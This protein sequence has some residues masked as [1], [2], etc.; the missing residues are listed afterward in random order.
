[1]TKAFD[2]ALRLLVRREHGAVELC[3][4]LKKKGFSQEE[5]KA[6]VEECQHLGYQ[7]DRR[8]VENYS[9]Y[10]MRQGYGP[11][12]ITQELNSK[13]IDQDLINEVLHL[14]QDNWLSN[15]K[16]VWNKKCKGQLNLSYDELQKQQR[17]LLYR[18]FSTDII[19][20]VVRELLT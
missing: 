8:F 10:R 1:M 4:K 9:R 3:V 19:S 18:G 13:N 11:L 2:S 17:F 6:A 14:E 20:R 16:E 12:K 15:A 7:S 5:A